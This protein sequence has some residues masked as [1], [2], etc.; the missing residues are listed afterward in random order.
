[1]TEMSLDA[2]KPNR[3]QGDNLKI[4]NRRKLLQPQP[5]ETK[6]RCK[7]IGTQEFTRK[8]RITQE[9]K[10]REGRRKPLR[11]VSCCYKGPP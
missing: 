6:G 11:K 9:A 10:G 8:V 3:R 5:R 1:M 7:I 4:G 2:E